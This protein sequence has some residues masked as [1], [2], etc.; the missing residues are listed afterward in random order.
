MEYPKPFSDRDKVFTATFWKELFS[1]LVTKLQM[2]SAYHPQ[3]DGQTE[4]VNQC[5]EMFLR[6][7]VHD[8][9][10]QWHKWLSSAELWYNTS[11][12]TALKCTPFKALYGVEANHGTVPVLNLD[13]SS[14]AATFLQ[15]RQSLLATLK[16]NLHK[17]QNK[18][19]SYADK[20]RTPRQ[21]H[22]GDMV[23]L[24]LQPYAQTSIANRPFPKLAF[25]FF[26]PYKIL[27]RVG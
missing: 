21:Y 26:G 24:K 6:S 10:K 18:M 22:E 19:K 4:R 13:D 16:D 14:E 3:I 25:K 7:A 9:P 5:L 11:Y 23:Y 17:A 27:E 2:S 12:H 15:D 20:G 8:S 1:L